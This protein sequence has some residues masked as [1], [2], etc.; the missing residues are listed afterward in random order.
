MNVKQPK[1]PRTQGPL[2]LQLAT[3]LRREIANGVLKAGQK[4]PTI[5]AMA[6]AKG[7][8]VITVRQAIEVLEAE[9]LLR[10]HQ[11][12]GTFVTE[13]PK[14]ATSL[15]LR[16][17]WGSL[18]EHLEGKRPTLIKMVDKVAT[19]MLD[20]RLGRLEP[21]YRF[22][23]RVHTY[24]DL[25]YALIN[26]YLSQRIADLAPQ[27]FEEGMVISQ[28]SRMPEARIARMQQR[29]SFTT[30][31]AETAELLNLPANAAI[32]DVLRVITDADG[33]A[34]YIGQTR[35]RGDFVH[36]EFDIQEPPK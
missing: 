24:D 25:P 15:T 14:V 22:M 29:I 36:L 34:I 10:R 6:E 2:Y 19:P 21:E 7:V 18:L 33:Q 4:L 5:A 1:E 23:R 13:A 27:A 26:I 11:G 20:P 35:Y 8:S 32:G 9:D 3:T 16:S 12:K 28:L 30:A 17:D 31:D